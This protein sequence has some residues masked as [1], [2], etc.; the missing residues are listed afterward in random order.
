LRY[1]ADVCHGQILSRMTRQIK[2]EEDL[3]RPERGS[4]PSGALSSPIETPP[5]SPIETLPPSPIDT[6]PPSPIE[7]PPPSPLETPPPLTAPPPPSTTPTSTGTPRST[8]IPLAT[9]TLVPSPTASG[10]P[11]PTPTP[12][13][14]PHVSVRIVASDTRLRVGDTLHV[15][16]IASNTGLGL[17]GLP[18]YRLTIQ[19][20]GDRAVFSP[21]APAPINHASIAPGQ[22]DSATFTL[23]ATCP[24]K[25]VLQASV[26]YEVHFGYP[27]PAV[28]WS[29][30]ASGPTVRVLP[31]GRHGGARC[32]PR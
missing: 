12:L 16:V 28:W 10:T 5:P 9:H 11:T 27:G 23:T 13:Q 31:H 32:G 2:I 14:P 1:A 26:T 19:T 25:A 24:G 15:E 22:T 8:P 3:R 18:Q 29:S 4:I 17:A 6:P 20:R 21:A 7:T 30:S